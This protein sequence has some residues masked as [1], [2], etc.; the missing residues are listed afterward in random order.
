[1]PGS[2]L[3]EKSELRNRKMRQR[4]RK[5]VLA[6]ALSITSGFTLGKFSSVKSCIYLFICFLHVRFFL[7]GESGEWVEWN[8]PA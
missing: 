3:C 6:P 1:M 4:N 2:P 7:G 5:R 8:T